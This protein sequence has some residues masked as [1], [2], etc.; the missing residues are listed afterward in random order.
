MSHTPIPRYDLVADNVPVTFAIR[1]MG[2]IAGMMQQGY[3]GE[4]HR[5]NYYTVIW[6]QHAEGVHYIDFQAYPL[7]DNSLFFV[8]PQQVHQVVAGPDAKGVVLLFTP[9]FLTNNGIRC[10]FI[11]NLYLFRDSSETPPLHVDPVTAQKLQRITDDIFAAFRSADD[12]KYETIGAYLKLFLI[13]CNSACRLEG[14]VPTQEDSGGSTLVR[15]FKEL[16]DRHFREKHKVTEYAALLHVTA[17]HLND[18]IRE[19]IGHNAKAYIQNRLIL[20]AKREALFTDR[21]AKEVG[22]YLGFDDPAHFSKFFK[23]GSGMSFHDFRES[24]HEKYN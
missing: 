17:N 14:P 18:V 20:E 7:E 23:Q 1:S 13:S 2:E 6:V 22:Y 8:T 21:S 3:F 16:V 5:H 12:Y 9:E 4:P 11:T 10:E 19:K 15:N 24:I